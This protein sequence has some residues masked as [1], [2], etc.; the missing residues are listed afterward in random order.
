MAADVATRDQ[1]TA[2]AFSCVREFL[3]RKGLD[4]TLAALDKEA[5]RDAGSINSR[6]E[7]LRTLNIGNLMRKNLSSANP[8]S[9]VL[10]TVSNFLIEKKRQKKALSTQPGSSS[11]S[12]S[13]SP[14]VDHPAM[15][16]AAPAALAQN[17]GKPGRKEARQSSSRV[18]PRPPQMGETGSPH[19]LS[20]RELRGRGRGPGGRSSFGLESGSDAASP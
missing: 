6:N 3:A 11:S 15:S 10:E 13:T 8:L 12:A 5:P 16:A 19:R 1:C 4:A 9:S 2:A 14:E 7:L 17:Q 20:S 18:L